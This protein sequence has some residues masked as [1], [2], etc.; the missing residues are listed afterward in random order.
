M[1]SST[2]PKHPGPRPPTFPK[3]GHWGPGAPD[4]PEECPEQEA[5]APGEPLY[6]MDLKALCAAA[7]KHEEDLRSQGLL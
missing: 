3:Q 1:A 2:L 5:P 7:D 6:K 4:T